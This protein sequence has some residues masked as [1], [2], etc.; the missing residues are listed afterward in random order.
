[1]TY[2]DLFNSISVETIELMI[3]NLHKNKDKWVN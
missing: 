3:K 2:D 1:M